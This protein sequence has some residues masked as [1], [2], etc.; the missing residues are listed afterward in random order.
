[1]VAGVVFNNAFVEVDATDIS[2]FIRSLRLFHGRD[3]VEDTAVGDESHTF[4]PGLKTTRAEMT[5]K[6]N[7]SASGPEAVLYPLI[8]NGTQATLVLRPD[9]DNPVSATNPSYTL[10]GHFVGEYM[11]LGGDVGALTESSI[12]FVLASGNKLTKAVS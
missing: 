8:D 4:T 10:V 11:P 5:V 2:T 9:K 1:M 3:Q 6:Q 12:T 7:Y